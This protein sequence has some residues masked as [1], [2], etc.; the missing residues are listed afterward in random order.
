M[1]PS[2]GQDHRI[3]EGNNVK[4]KTERVFGFGFYLGHL[5]RAGGR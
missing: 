4:K 1:L 3:E 2:E 5:E